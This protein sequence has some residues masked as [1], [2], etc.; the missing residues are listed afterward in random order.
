MNP[1]AGVG[2][3]RKFSRKELLG[4][5]AAGAGAVLLGGCGG[6]GSSSGSGGSGSKQITLGSIGWNEDIAVSTLTKI[7]MQK[8]FGYSVQIKGPLDVGP[9]FEGVAKGYL[10]AFQD[11]W[12]PNHKKYLAKV[13]SEVTLLPPWFQGKTRYD[14]AVPAYMKNIKSI[15]DLPKTGLHQITG[16]EPGAAINPQIRNHVFPEYHLKGWTLVTSSTAAMLAQ[17]QKKYQA[18]QPIVFLAWSPHWMNVRYNI[19][20]LKDP[21][22]ALGAFNNPSKI[23]TL[24]NKNLKSKDPVTYAFLKAIKLDQNQ[25]NQIELEINKAGATNPEKGVKNWL[26]KNGS[27]VK[28]WISAAKQAKKG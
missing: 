24:I 18:R 15:A 17:L 14:I 28:P 21:K 5:G 7:L 3:H 25:V 6:A 16:I 11:V 27:V 1:D 4:I 26:S 10:T 9:L 2:G 20:Y 19:R 8:N 23:T 12:M 22:N 13:K